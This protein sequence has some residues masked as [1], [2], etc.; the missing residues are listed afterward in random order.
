VLFRSLALK[1]TYWIEKLSATD[2]RIGYNI[3]KGGI[4]GDTFTLNPNREQ[5]REK[6]RINST[7]RKHT[8]ETKEKIRKAKEGIPFSEQHK[9]NLKENHKGFSG[10]NQSEEAKERARLLRLG[11]PFPKVYQ[12]PTCDKKCSN[13]FN[14]ERHYNK[15]KNLIK[16]I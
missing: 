8:E 10:H 6:N 5:S 7:G 4:G 11:Q 14:L 16:K 9:S 15:C 13:T 3:T 2:S 1:E 12:C